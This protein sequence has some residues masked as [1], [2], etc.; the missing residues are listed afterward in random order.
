MSNPQFRVRASGRGGSGYARPPLPGEKFKYVKNADGEEIPAVI[1]EAGRPIIVPVITTVIKVADGSGLIQWSVDQ[2]AAYAVANLDSLYSR[3]ME[4]G[5][6]FLRFYHKR[7]PDLSDPLR[8]AHKGVL[9]DLAEL[10]TNMHD[11][12]E[13]DLQG[14]RL[15][16][17]INCIEMEEMIEAWE[18]WK[19]EHDIQVV[20]T[21]VTLWGDDYAG[22][23][24]LLAWIDG[25][26]WLIDVKTSRRVGPSHKMQLAALRAA[27]RNY[28]FDG[29]NWGLVDLPQP[30]R[31]GFIQV[32][33]NDIDNKGEVIPAFV[34][35]HPMTQKE[36]D[37]Q[38]QRFIACLTINQIDYELK[39]A[40][41]S[42][43]EE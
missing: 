43:E 15:P 31:Y 16:P 22:T 19:F 5:F 35:L 14:D 4:Q 32:R 42:D 3:T 17:D 36:L 13:A 40:T 30:T 23:F 1:D 24:D 6:G 37:L 12:I 11:W 41:L 29:K 39:S 26:L 33:P 10:G 7:T 34:E 38:Y 20:A 8:T 9:N 27:D 28:E 25:E 2:V 21:E 18:A